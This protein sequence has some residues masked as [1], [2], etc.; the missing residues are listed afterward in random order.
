MAGPSEERHGIAV[1]CHTEPVVGRYGESPDEVLPDSR[2]GARVPA[3]EEDVPPPAVLDALHRAW[4]RPDDLN[5]RYLARIHEP[6]HP[7]RAVFREGRGSRFAGAAEDDVGQARDGRIRRRRP[8]FELDPHE[9]AI[10]V[11]DRT[12]HRVMPRKP[13]LDE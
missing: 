13:R 11:G 10:V 12:L 4:R 1:E 9:P 7:R 6:P 5:A 3:L 8:A 2:E